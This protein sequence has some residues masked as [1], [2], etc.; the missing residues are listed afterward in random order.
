[1]QKIV[2]R[3][4]HE[5]DREILLLQRSLAEKE[6]VQ[7]T[8]EVLCRSL[9]DETHQLRRTLAATAEMCQH[10]AKCLEEKQAARGKSEERIPL[11]RLDKLQFPASEMPLQEA[12]ICKLQE[13]NTLLKQKVI[14]VEDLNAKWQKYDAS[15]DEY[16]KGLHLQL[17]AAQEQAAQ[18]AGALRMRKEIFRLNKLLEDKLNDCGQVRRELEELKKAR[19]GDK[20]RVQI[21]EE[22][23]LVYRDDFTSER[24]DRERAQGQIQELQEQVASLQQQLASRQ[25]AREGR[26]PWRIPVGH[27]SH[28]AVGSGAAE[29]LPLEGGSRRAP[30]RSQQSA[31]QVDAPGPARGDQGDLQCPHCMRLF[32]DEQGEELL[33]HVA[34]CC[35]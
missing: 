31:V 22:Q 13:E 15:R 27:K 21:L 12:V 4:Q 33:R 6:K 25:E 3:P 7:A 11:E 34:E 16:V 8:S 2:A 10:L 32:D 14:Y 24:A 30:A 28:A 29:P 18:G 20:E 1:M 17:K 26:G 35:Q 5:R 19:D 23:V 9:T